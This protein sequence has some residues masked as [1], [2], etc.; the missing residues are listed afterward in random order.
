MACTNLSTLDIFSLPCRLN[1]L[2][3]KGNTSHK[4]QLQNKQVKNV[5]DCKKLEFKKFFL[6]DN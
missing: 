1:I 5:N 3:A 2:P 4:I 6:V